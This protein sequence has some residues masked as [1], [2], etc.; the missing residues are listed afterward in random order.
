MR[1]GFRF[2]FSRPIFSCE[3]LGHQVLALMLRF[4]LAADNVRHYFFLIGLLAVGNTGIVPQAQD[5]GRQAMVEFR[6]DL[7]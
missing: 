3:Q 2:R 5:I 7:E 1:F 4:T 6:Q